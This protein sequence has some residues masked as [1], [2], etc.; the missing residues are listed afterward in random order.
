[1]LL[2]F[3]S[4]QDSVVAL[5]NVKKLNT[6]R[7][8]LHPTAVTTMNLDARRRIVK[9]LPWRLQI[10][11]VVVTDLR[12]AVAEAEVA[13]DDVILQAHLPALLPHPQYHVDRT[14]DHKV[15]HHH[16]RN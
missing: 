9:N 14:I 7:D 10:A 2:S 4:L 8:V 16:Q 5:M 6:N 13:V 11:K 1:M 3:I 12:Q 15:A